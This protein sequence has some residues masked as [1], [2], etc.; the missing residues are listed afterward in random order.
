[1]LGYPFAGPNIEKGGS[2]KIKKS[3]LKKKS[4]SNFRFL[5][6]DFGL[7]RSVGTGARVLDGLPDRKVSVCCCGG[8]GHAGWGVPA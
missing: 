4:K 2:L 6:F 7:T 3:K 5:I 1:M 8:G